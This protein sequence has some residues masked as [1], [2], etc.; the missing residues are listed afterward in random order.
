MTCRKET[1]APFKHFAVYEDSAVTIAGVAAQWQAAEGGKRFFCPTC[2]SHV[3]YKMSQSNEIEINVGAFDAPPD[4]SPTYEVWCV[5]RATW[6][7][8]LNVTQY[9][10]DRLAP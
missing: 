5:R 10:K 7:P 9:A 2:G 3:F 6:L 4:L 1:G 8:D